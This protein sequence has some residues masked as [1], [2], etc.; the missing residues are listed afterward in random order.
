MLTP[1]KELAIREAQGTKIALLTGSVFVRRPMIDSKQDW[2]DLL[3]KENVDGE[4]EVKYC[5]VDLLSFTDSEEE[6]CDDDPV[7][8]LLYGVRIFHGYKEKR[9][10]DSNSTDDF[11]A[12][13]LNLRNAYLNAD[14]SVGS[15]AIPKV[16]SLPLIQSGFILLGE[17][18]LSGAFGHYIDLQAPIEVR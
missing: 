16:E 13:I 18:P 12:L 2:V 6:G 14:R 3:G 15:P 11:I 1:E 9:S 17:D 10:D 4:Y 5:T 7:V 8:N